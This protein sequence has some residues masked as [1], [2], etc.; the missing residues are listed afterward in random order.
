MR[1]IPKDVDVANESGAASCLLGSY[2]W[3][4][5]SSPDLTQFR[6]EEKVVPQTTDVDAGLTSH[7]TPF[8]TGNVDALEGPLL[9]SWGTSTVTEADDE[10]QLAFLQ[11]YGGMDLTEFT[12]RYLNGVPP[13]LNVTLDILESL[14]NGLLRL[15]E[16]GIVHGDLKPENVKCMEK[17]YCFRVIDSNEA[18]GGT[19]AFS[20][21]EKLCSPHFSC[22]ASDIWSVALTVAVTLD[23]RIEA[24]VED[25]IRKGNVADVPKI[26]CYHLDSRL[27]EQRLAGQGVVVD[28]IIKMIADMLHLDSRCRP[29]PADV[30]E[31]CRDARWNY[32][33]PDENISRGV[34]NGYGDLPT[35]IPDYEQIKQEYKVTSVKS[36]TTLP[37]YSSTQF[38]LRA[39]N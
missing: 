11:D 5:S 35:T 14:C 1:L 23:S 29:E 8:S 33:W 18:P 22:Y 38:L 34:W 16:V 2:A 4:S 9:L 21:P 10:A 26:V 25:A 27:Q 3:L 15:R 6:T 37:C 32:R 24:L 7:P 36:I 30:I 12:N 20:A 28:Q 17:D 13:R 19:L 39:K 31:Q